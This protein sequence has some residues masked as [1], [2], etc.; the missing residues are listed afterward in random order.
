M[1]PGGLRVGL[2]RGLP[3]HVLIAALIAAGGAGAASSDAATVVPAIVNSR[4]PSA[5]SS[6]MSSR[7]A[8]CYKPAVKTSALSRRLLSAAPT[9]GSNAGPRRSKPMR[10]GEG[11]WRS[12]IR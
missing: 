3:T 8:C 7:S 9:C 1:R 11:G 6:A 4:A 10:M 12:P 5:M 2:P